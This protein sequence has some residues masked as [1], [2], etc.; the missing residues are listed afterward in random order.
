MRELI[1]LQNGL[2]VVLPGV[3]VLCGL[4]ATSVASAVVGGALVWLWY[5]LPLDQ[6][7]PIEGLEASPGWRP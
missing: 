4:V 7:R 3:Q 2:R 1:E 5:G 6:P